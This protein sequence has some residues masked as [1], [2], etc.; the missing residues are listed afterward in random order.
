MLTKR[1]VSPRRPPFRE[2]LP[3]STSLSHYSWDVDG[4][5]TSERK[6][7]VKGERERVRV[8]ET[9]VKCPHC[10]RTCNVAFVLGKPP[11]FVRCVWCGELQPADS[12]R[13]IMY[14]LGLPPMR[15]PH[16]MNAVLPSP[17]E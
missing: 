14:G 4:V 11:Q 10:G 9:I 13:V 1:D 17:G 5:D 7:V 15:K 16:E 8:A 3:T 12:Y 6:G 2:K